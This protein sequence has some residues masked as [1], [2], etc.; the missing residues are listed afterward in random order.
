MNYNIVDN[1]IP[2]LKADCPCIGLYKD[3]TLCEQGHAL[4]K[5]LEGQISQSISQF[6]IDSDPGTSFFLPLPSEHCSSVIIL[7]MGD[8]KKLKQGSLSKVFSALAAQAKASKV[9]ALLCLFESA[10]EGSEIS[11]TQLINNLVRAIADSQYCFDQYKSKKVPALRLETVDIAFNQA[12][13]PELKEACL[14]AQAQM[15]GMAATRTL[16]NLPGNVC[17]PTYLAEQA[18]ELAGNSD[19]IELTILEESDMEA[20]NMGAF[21]SVSKGSS[22]L[23]YT[24]P[25]PRDQRGSRMPSSA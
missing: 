23:L 9:K 7:G 14:I 20:L 15:K 17:T 25:S 13:H 11:P 3:Q 4:D 10:T 6:D 21:L 19:K 22:C 16:G 18:T 5:R 24:S 2:S 8:K 12:A 1:P